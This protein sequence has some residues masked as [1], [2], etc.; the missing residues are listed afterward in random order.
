ML[1]DLQFVVEPPSAHI[2][3]TETTVATQS[4]E[5]SPIPFQ[6]GG[7]FHIV[8]TTK[9]R[10][11]FLPSFGGIEGGPDC[12]LIGH[13]EAVGHVAGER[14]IEYGGT[15]AVVFYD[16][17]DAGH[18]RACLPSKGRTR[19]EN[20]LQIGIAATKVLYQRYEQVDVVALA[21]HQMTASEIEPL[22]LWQPLA[23]LLFHVAQAF[24]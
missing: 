4:I 9:N 10:N 22:E 16:I 13:F 20:N 21:C 18:Q 24:L 15:D 1:P 11:R 12:G 17:D 23:E 2:V 3:A 8:F 6:R 14:H 5:T 19:F 7:I